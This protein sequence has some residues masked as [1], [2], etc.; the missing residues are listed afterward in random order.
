VTVRLGIKVGPDRWRDKLEDPRVPIRLLVERAEVYFDLA[1][2][3]AYG[4]LFSWLRERGMR[5]GLHASTTLAGGLMPNLGS[6][7]AVVRAAS[8]SLLRRTIDVAA[9]AGMRHVVVHPGSCRDWGIRGGRTYCRG[10]PATPG[11]RDRQI[12]DGVLRLAAYAAEQD[13]ALLAENM[14]AYDFASYDPV[15]RVHVVD[16]GFVPYRLLAGLGERGVGLCVD[17]GH[18]YGEMSAQ[19]PGVDPTPQVMAATRAL[20]PYARLVHLSTVVPP[21]NGTD[22][23]NGFLDEDYALGAIPTRAQL[24]G[25]LGLFSGDGIC[26]IPEPSGEAAVHLDNVRVLRSWMEHPA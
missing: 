1:R 19:R 12:I 21:W 10:A 5:G 23:H 2:L 20:A 6:A 9:E 3:D 24:L 8:A 16:V 18:L 4:P 11:E 13:V 26:A 15:D 14:P 7:D 22:S 17:V 25:W